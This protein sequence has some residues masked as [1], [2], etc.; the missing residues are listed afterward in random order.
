MWQDVVN[1]ALELLAVAA[2]TSSIRTM[3]RD[4]RVRGISPWH[5]GY[6]LLSASW[7]VYYYAHLDQWWSF[8]AAVAYW[9]ATGAWVGLVV[10]YFL[11]R[12]ILC[13]EDEEI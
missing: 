12:G 8:S 5:I 10:Y 3:L 1:S 6:A 2:V 7:F 4:K 9:L 11:V 13:G